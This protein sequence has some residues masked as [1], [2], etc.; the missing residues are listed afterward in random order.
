EVDLYSGSYGT[1]R[2]ALKVGGQWGAVNAIGDVSRFQT[3]GYR[4]H[5]AATR[6]HFNG[7]LRYGGLTMVANSMRQPDTQDPL[8]LTRAQFEA[9]PRQATPQA[10]QFNTRKSISQDQ[11][12]GT[13]KQRVGDGRA[14]ALLYV[15][16]REVEQ[17]LAIPL[18][19]Q[20]GTTHSGGV[21]NLERN[22]GGAALRWFTNFAGVRLSVGAEYDVMYERRKG[23]INNNGV[24]VG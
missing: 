5:S 10:I 9:D 2:S 20:A 11:V 7:K 6:D 8:G 19:T 14:E 12:G 22:Y 15:G 1:W 24:K 18:A 16:E 17:Y 13:Y 23:Y 4:D 21:V 3:D